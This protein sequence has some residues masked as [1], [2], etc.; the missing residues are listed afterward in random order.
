MS[1]IKN[2]L[3]K[4]KNTE[5]TPIELAQFI[6]F[7][8]DELKMLDIFWNPT[9]NKGWIYLSDEIILDNLTNET[10]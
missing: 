6:G 9:F 8:K 7:S 5:V 4:F 3:V 1:E 2:S 10:C